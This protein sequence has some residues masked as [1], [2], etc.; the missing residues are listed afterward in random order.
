MLTPIQASLRKNE[1]FAYNNFLDKRKKKSKNYI[2]DL[3]ITADLKRSFSKSE[4]TNLSYK[5]YKQF[6][7]DTIP[8]YRLDNL[9]EK[10]NEAL[11][12]KT[13]LSMKK[14]R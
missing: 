8:S 13:E 9:P 10:Y 1:V 3:V 14:K 7:N 4:T 5:L 2:N 11:L 6:I 12:K